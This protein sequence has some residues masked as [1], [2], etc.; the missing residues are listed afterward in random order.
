MTARATKI[1][2]VKKLLAGETHYPRYSLHCYGGHFQMEIETETA[3]RSCL[4]FE[5]KALAFLKAHPK[6][7]I[8]IYKLPG[9]PLPEWSKGKKANVATIMPGMVSP[10]VQY[11]AWQH[12]TLYDR[13][14]FEIY[15]AQ[16][17]EAEKEIFAGFSR[18]QRFL[19]HEL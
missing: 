7:E 19:T 9:E 13:I 14:P 11:F 4:F 18:I 3:S 15:S 6:T 2:K 5:P 16:L 8:T 12:P 17:T 1:R 10:L